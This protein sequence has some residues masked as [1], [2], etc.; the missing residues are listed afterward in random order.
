M[1]FSI[2]KRKDNNQAKQQKYDFGYLGK[3]KLRPDFIKLNIN[4]RESVALDHWIQEGFAHVSR[5]QVNQNLATTSYADCLFFMSGTKEDSAL[6]GLIQPSEDSSGR[7]YPFSSFVN[8]QQTAYKSHPSCLFLNA[9]Q[10]IEHLLGTT[11]Q[12]FASGSVLEMESQ[13]SQ[14][15]QV[16]NALKDEFH[17]HIL[18]DEMRKIPMAEFWQAIGLAD[19]SARASLIEES[20]LLLQSMANRGCLRSQF[21]LKLPMPEFSHQG[22]II[23]AFWLHLITMMVADHNWQPWFFYHLGDQHNQ[24]SI[25]VFTRPVPASYF[26]AI[27]SPEIKT[28]GVIDLQKLKSTKAASAQ[29]VELAGLDNMSMYDALRRWCKPV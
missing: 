27:W 4:F 17:P 21:G 20:S 2:F 25:T 15:T 13:A 24:P 9:T 1:M 18:I 26:S 28:S 3:T 19:I 22:A 5:E 23:G 14:L 11:K 16:A 8:C 10:A 6:L 29:S 12:I 7:K